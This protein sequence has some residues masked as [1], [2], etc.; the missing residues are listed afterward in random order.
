MRID[1]LELYYVVFPLIYPWRTA[2][3]AD[4]DVHTILVKLFG[5]TRGM[6]GNDA[7]VRP[8][9]FPRILRGRLSG[10]PRIPCPPGCRPG[11]PDRP[12]I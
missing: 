12:G 8:L 4:P 1:R 9:L 6:G 10:H 2:Y 5:Q 7:P 11:L 3:G